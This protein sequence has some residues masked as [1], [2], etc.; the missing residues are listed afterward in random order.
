MKNFALKTSVLAVASVFA[1]AVH[2]GT[3]SSP[4]TAYAAEALISSTDVTLNS[5]VYTMGVARGDGQNFVIII[6][7]SAGNTFDTTVVPTCTPANGSG[8]VGADTTTCAIKRFSASELAFEVSVGDGAGAGG[9][10]ANDTYT[11]A[12]LVL[13]DHTLATAGST[14]TLSVALKDPGET[15]F[16]D[17]GTALNSTIARSVNAVNVYAAASDTF[18]TADVNHASGPL[19]GYI[20]DASAPA[21]TA[22]RAQANLT[23]DNNSAG[24]VIADGA[25]AF[26]FTTTTG[27]VTVNLSDTTNFQALGTNGLCI[28]ADADASVCEAG[29]IF[30]VAGTP[31]VGSLTLGSASFPATGSTAPR[32]VSYDPSLTA[33]L[34]TNRTIGVSG[35]VT[36]QVGAA[37]AFA[38]TGSANSTF[39]VWNANAIQLYAP[40][41]TTFSGFNSRI[42]LTN[43]GA[44]AVQYSMTCYGESGTGTATGTAPTGTIPAGGVKMVTAQE[45]C[46]FGTATRG[47]VVATINAPASQIKGAYTIVNPTSGAVSTVNMERPFGAAT[48]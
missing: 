13:E 33:S 16:V 4:N 25:T 31:A 39:W 37:H 44:S 21:D 23:F 43:I 5:I 46:N 40:F 32:T 26:D 36:P 7:P 22:N 29:E 34:G 30:A 6:T 47:S 24:A 14:V 10:E 15:S 17:Q 9:I 12:S 1:G 45:A 42:Y 3:V 8:D 28:N 11:V 41:V 20:V 35:T 27:T 19:F 38:D 2:A 18:T 48:Y